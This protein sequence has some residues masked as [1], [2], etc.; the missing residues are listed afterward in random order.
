MP[1]VTV[2]IVGDEQRTRERSLAQLLADAV[3]GVL[4][5]SPG[6]TW[7][8]VRWLGHENYAEN[9]T[10]V[11]AGELPVFVSVLKR[12]P[13]VGPELEAE[14]SALTRAIADVIGRSANLVHIEYAPP[15]AG[16]VSFGGKLI[17]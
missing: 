16:R 7:V 9:G 8:R 2:E 1:I 10:A 15:A 5:S 14:V 3:A 4:D 17:Q 6:Q 11:S 12:S 13:P